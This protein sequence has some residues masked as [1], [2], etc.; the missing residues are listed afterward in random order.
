MNELDM[1]KETELPRAKLSLCKVKNVDTE[2]WSFI[3]SVKI[4]NSLV[5]EYRD[6]N[7]LNELQDSLIKAITKEIKEKLV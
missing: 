7:K 6:K 2:E 3:T 5:Q 4:K 1:S